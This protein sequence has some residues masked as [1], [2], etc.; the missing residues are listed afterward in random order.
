MNNEVQHRSIWND[1]EGGLYK[2]ASYEI[3]LD[4]NMNSISRKY[5]TMLTLIG[6]TGSIHTGLM[7]I[8]GII[9]SRW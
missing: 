8:F 3:F 4:N 2:F 7:L 5:E 9:L 1:Y 6:E